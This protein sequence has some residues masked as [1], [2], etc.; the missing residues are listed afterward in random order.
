MN[1]S[2]PEDKPQRSI[3]QNR[4]IHKYFVM[5]AESLNNAALDVLTVLNS[6]V[7]IEW[8]SEL[9]ILFSS[10]LALMLNNSGLTF[11]CAL[12]KGG[13]VKWSSEA[14]KELLWKKV[15]HLKFGIDSTTKLNTSQVSE[16][17]EVINRHIASTF[18]VSVVFPSKDN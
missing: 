2:T 15:Q 14:V 18:G 13:K 8:N 4:A 7:E 3:T 10:E 11:H 12:G 5:L 17:Y 1:Y 9:V 16:I 6:D